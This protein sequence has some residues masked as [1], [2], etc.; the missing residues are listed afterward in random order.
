MEQHIFKKKYGQNFLNDSNILEKIYKS[1]KYDENAVKLVDMSSLEKIKEY[2]DEQILN[3]IDIIKNQFNDLLQSEYFNNNLL[4]NEFLNIGSTSFSQY[5]NGI[6]PF[7]GY[8]YKKA[9]PRYLRYV[10][11]LLFSKIEH[12]FFKQ[13]NRRWIVLKDDMICYMNDPNKMIG[14]NVYWFDENIEIYKI[15]EKKLKI[16]NLSINL[17]FHLS[18]SSIRTKV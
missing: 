3:S 18:K 10:M 8:A 6:K 1:I 13:R 15:K 7:E 16:E 14:K 9:D 2:N 17:N 11:K 5:N 4:I 12:A